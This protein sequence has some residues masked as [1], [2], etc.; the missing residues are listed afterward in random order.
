MEEI[1]KE[2]MH[3]ETG[4]HKEETHCRRKA[5]GLQPSAERGRVVSS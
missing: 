4:S 5:M 1:N 3:A 2:E